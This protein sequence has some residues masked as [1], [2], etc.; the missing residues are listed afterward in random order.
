MLQHICNK[1]N[2]FG[3][4]VKMCEMTVE[5]DISGRL[6]PNCLPSMK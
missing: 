4:T 3:N 2:A 1:L 6:P 5:L